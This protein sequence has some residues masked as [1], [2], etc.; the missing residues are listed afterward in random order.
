MTRTGVGVAALVAAAAI[1][2]ACG[3][4]SATGGD[5]AGADTSPG[6]D[7][8]VDT[9]MS[10]KDSQTADTSMPDAADAGDAH[11]DAKE[12]GPEAGPDAGPYANT[13]LADNPVAYYRLGEAAGP[14]AVNASAGGAAF[15]ATYNNFAAGQ[16]GKMGLIA[17]DPNTAVMCD[18][19][20]SY[21]TLPLDAAN[22]ALEFPAGF[23]IEAWV[24]LTG[25]TG[26]RT[27]ASTKGAAGDGYSFGVNG[28]GALFLACHGKFNFGSSLAMPTDG[29]THYVAAVFDGSTTTTFYLDDQT[30]VVTSGAITNTYTTSTT[31]ALCRF[32]DG[33]DFDWT[34]VV[35]EVAL[36]GTALAPARIA[37]HRVA[38]GGPP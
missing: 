33:Q 31:L 29:S 1:A 35:D 23:T 30:S 3:D 19:T 34:G 5:D 22:S 7:A 24:Q 10:E 21:L 2:S 37:A 20:P 8:T 4:D 9:S 38:G 12:A 36:F 6:V 26:F 11:P 28:V 25:T 13:V 17:G 16:F 15:N 18:T 14:T 27:I 32:G